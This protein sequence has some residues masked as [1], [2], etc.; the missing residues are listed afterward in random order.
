MRSA[1][2]HHFMG[3]TQAP[4]TS[5]THCAVTPAS[6]QASL[7][8]SHSNV[9]VT[10]DIADMKLIQEGFT[11]A[12]DQIKERFEGLESSITTTIADALA[13][14]PPP[15]ANAF[16]RSFAGMNLTEAL[17]SVMSL[18]ESSVMTD[19]V[20]RIL[21]VVH[22]IKLLPIIER[23]KGQVNPGTTSNVLINSK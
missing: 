13:N 4:T 2:H 21:D 16:T 17:Q 11:N 23:P 15:V 7:M 18:V 5:A 10:A 1:G 20:T 22:F 12:L 3:S 14:F 8:H 19:V 9:S 6:S